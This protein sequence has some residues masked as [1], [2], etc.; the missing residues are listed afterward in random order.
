M[1]SVRS[2]QQQPHAIFRETLLY[3]THAA[4]DLVYPQSTTTSKSAHMGAHANATVYYLSTSIPSGSWMR[5]RLPTSF[6]ASSCETRV[7]MLRAACERSSVHRAAD[8]CGVCV[9]GVFVCRVGSFPFLIPFPW[10]WETLIRKIEKI[11]K[12]RSKRA[13]RRVIIFCWKGLKKD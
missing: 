13:W 11:T 8:A 9:T 3:P 5:T 12:L 2:Y 7:D 10:T 4:M 6:C 1:Q